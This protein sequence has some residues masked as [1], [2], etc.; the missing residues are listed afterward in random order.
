MLPAIRK[1]TRNATHRIT[2]TKSLE[3]VLA[4]LWA[5]GPGASRAFP[6][7][8]AFPILKANPPLVV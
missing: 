1:A 4:G 8:D 2:T 5:S 3:Y 6:S 7:L